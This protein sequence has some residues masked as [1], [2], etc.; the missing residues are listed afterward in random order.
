M[1]YGTVPNLENEN[2]IS[3]PVGIFFLIIFYAVFSYHF[4]RFLYRT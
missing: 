2:Q 3:F 1:S 4:S